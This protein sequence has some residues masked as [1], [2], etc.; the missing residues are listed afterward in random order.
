MKFKTVSGSTYEIQGGTVRRVN[1]G[2]G[3]RAD[4]DWIELFNPNVVVEVGEPV[5]A[6]SSGMADF[7]TKVFS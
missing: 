2:Y 3:K 5:I 7:N 1:E 6:A 4:G